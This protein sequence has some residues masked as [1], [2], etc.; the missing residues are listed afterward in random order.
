MG[1]GG[2]P[3]RGNEISNERSLS[4]IG[5]PNSKIDRYKNGIKVQTRWY[6]KDGKAVR[7]R[8]FI[9]QNSNGT[10][11]F[12]HDHIW[13]WNGDKGERNHNLLTPKYD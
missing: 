9:H 11:F 12:P 6:G 4:P 8:D 5:K 10:H 3:N 13:T 7:N 2:V 1:A